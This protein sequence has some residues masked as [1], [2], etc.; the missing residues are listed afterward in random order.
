MVLDF[1]KRW[2]ELKLVKPSSLS[3]QRAKCA[4]EK[5]VFLSGLAHIMSKYDITDKP[6][7]I[8]NIDEKGI[9]TEYKPP[10]VVAR[11]VCKP[12]AVM[13][14]MSKTVTIIGAGNALGHQIPPFFV[15]PGE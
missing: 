12:Q 4:S 6:Q 3:E 1:M 7:N 9:N 13:A 10:N 8:Y 11:S 5:C 2:P 15:F 14:E